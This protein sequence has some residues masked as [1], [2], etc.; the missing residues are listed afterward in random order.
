VLKHGEVNPLNVFG[1]REVGHC[2]PHFTRVFYVLMTSERN[3]KNWIYDNLSGRFWMGDIY[4][5]DS[6]S[7]T[8]S[9]CVAF[10]LGSEASFFT[11]VLD[12]F[13]CPEIF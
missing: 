2:P 4:D 6:S 1:L 9:A 3:I 8:T 12:Q 13:N 7:G 10:E 5:P 11:L